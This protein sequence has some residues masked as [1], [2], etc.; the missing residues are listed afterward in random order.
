M[1]YNNLCFIWNFKKFEVYKWDFK[2]VTFAKMLF[3][4]SVK[5]IG[6]ETIFTQM[7]VNLTIFDKEMVS[8]IFK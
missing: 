8:N 3:F 4:L 5:K 6:V 7:L 2:L 1:Y